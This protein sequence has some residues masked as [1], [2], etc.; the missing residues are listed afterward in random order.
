MRR[1]RRGQRSYFRASKG[2]KCV[3]RVDHDSN[4]MIGKKTSEAWPIAK[5]ETRGEEKCQ[6]Q[7]NNTSRSDC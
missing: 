1:F 2:V 3:A 7:R 4:S 5:D 6:R